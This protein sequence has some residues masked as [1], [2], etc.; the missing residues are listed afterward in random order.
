MVSVGVAA[1]LTMLLLAASDQLAAAISSAAGNASGHFL[2]RASGTVGILTLLSGSP[3]L[4]F[5]VGTFTAAAALVLWL[6]LLMR[7]AA[8]YVIVLM[9]P[10]AFAALVWPARR[11]WAI[12][13][14]EL[15]VAL[16][17]S[18]FAIVAVLA[19]GG[20]AITQGSG[21]SITAALAGAVLVF[22][23]AFAPWA[24]LRLIPLAE[25]ASSAAGSL[26]TD[27]ARMRPAWEAAATYGNRIENWAGSL[28]SDLREQAREVS[29]ASADRGGWNGTGGELAAV[30]QSAEDRTGV[31]SSEP[32]AIAGAAPVGAEPPIEPRLQPPIEPPPDEEAPS[33]WRGDSPPVLGLEG[34][35]RSEHPVPPDQ[36]PL[37]PHP[38][39]ESGQ[40]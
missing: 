32:D 39:A 36:D 10:L 37:P 26:R 22:M 6:E 3:F 4:A 20:A 12:R 18:K 8:V 5:L 23:G 2:D 29:T 14:V 38:N 11:V 28:T 35:P 1:P 13:A 34:F 27:G 24:L 15:L 30:L 21:H 33:P 25:L 17:L 9:L 40:S 31:V 7:Q 16:I 19:L